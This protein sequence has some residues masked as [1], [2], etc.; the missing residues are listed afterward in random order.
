MTQ[1]SIG[2]KAVRKMAL[3]LLDE[4]NGISKKAFELLSGM[5]VETENEDI[6]DAVDMTEDRVYIG[7]DFAEEELAKLD[8]DEE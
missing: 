1:V 6:L 2:P 4:E 7:E 3:L 5:L 8:G